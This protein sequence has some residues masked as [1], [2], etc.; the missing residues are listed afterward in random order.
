MAADDEAQPIIIF[1]ERRNGGGN[2]AAMKLLF[3]FLSGVG[4]R[5]QHYF[6]CFP[7]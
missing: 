7:P 2:K 5:E 6:F 3:C 1:D 4:H